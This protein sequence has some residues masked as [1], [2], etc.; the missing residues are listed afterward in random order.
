MIA[1]GSGNEHRDAIPRCIL[2]SFKSG[3]RK[4]GA[5]NGGSQG[6]TL[7]TPEHTSERDDS[8]PKADVE[9]GNST[10]TSREGSKATEH[11]NNE[12][13]EKQGTGLLEEESEHMKERGS[14]PWAKE[15][16]DQAAR[17]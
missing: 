3:R 2:R 9:N 14:V 13:V 11:G 12:D 1:A 16:R 7:A 4:Q 5:Q 15:E 6:T 8:S 10:A 17:I